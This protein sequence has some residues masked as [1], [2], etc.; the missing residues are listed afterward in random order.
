MA[1]RDRAV[2]EH[3]STRLT[4]EMTALDQP[5]CAGERE[6]KND[7]RACPADAAL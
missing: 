1:L 6:H 3:L 4:S 2:M 5:P 7:R